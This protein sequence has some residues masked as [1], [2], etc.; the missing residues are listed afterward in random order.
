MRATARLA[1]AVWSPAPDK[2]APWTGD[3][4]TPPDRSHA[5]ARGRTRRP[6]PAPTAPSPT[7]LFPARP[8]A[9]GAGVETRREQIP[10]P[11][12]SMTKFAGATLV[13]ARAGRLPRHGTGQA[14][15]LRRCSLHVRASRRRRRGGNSQGASPQPGEFHDEIRRGDPC[16][17]PR[18]TG[19]LDTGRDK[20]VPYAV[21]PCTSASRRRRRGGN[22]QG[23]IP[24]PGEFH[25]EIRRGDPCGRPP[26]TGSLDTGRDKPVPYAVVPCTSASRR[27]RR[28]GN[29]QG[30][31]P[32]P[33]EFH[34]EIRR[35]DPCG[36]PPRTGSLD[37]GRDKPVPYAVVP[38]TSASRRRRGGNSQG[39]NPQPG[40][41]HDEI[42]SGRGD[43]IAPVTPP[44]PPDVRFSRI[45][46]LAPVDVT[47]V[48]PR[49]LLV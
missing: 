34:D 31:S 20:P 43:G 39:A 9:G 49:S 30:A 4:T 15:P 8:R 3:G 46:R 36:R 7:P 26:R 22:S 6:A 33:G 17:R 32:Q 45:R 19:S 14:R 44:T 37:T 2:P 48:R 11:A 29:S 1:G 24:Q 18:Q 41:F 16:G 10:N 27:R 38:C 12:N 25:D 28:G 42:R 35:G 5:P 13:V 47:T 23:A 21:V 40:E